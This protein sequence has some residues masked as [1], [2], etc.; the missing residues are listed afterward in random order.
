MRKLL[1]MVFGVLLYLDGKNT[2]LRVNRAVLPFLHDMLKIW[3]SI[4]FLF[5]L[6]RDGD[7]EN[8]KIVFGLLMKLRMV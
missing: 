2:S 4:T 7:V 6:I 3:I 8:K 1:A 5:V